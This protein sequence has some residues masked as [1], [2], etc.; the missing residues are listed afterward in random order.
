MTHLSQRQTLACID[1][2]GQCRCPWCGHFAR[3]DDMRPVPDLVIDGARVSR[4]PKCATCA[5]TYTDAPMCADF[6]T[7]ETP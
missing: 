6:H 1:T 5:S 2:R 4:A 7:E 3:L